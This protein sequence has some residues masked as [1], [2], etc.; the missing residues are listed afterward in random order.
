LDNLKEFLFND[1]LTGI[2][3]LEGA[4]DAVITL[5]TPI[6]NQLPYDSINSNSRACVTGW[7]MKKIKKNI[8]NQDQM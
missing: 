5:E 1:N 6:P 3:P 2:H 8:Q 4:E 7:V